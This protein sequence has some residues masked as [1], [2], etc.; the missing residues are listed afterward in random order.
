MLGGNLTYPTPLVRREEISEDIFHE[1][2]V[3]SINLKEARTLRR[4]LGYK[5]KDVCDAAIKRFIN[6]KRKIEEK[7]SQDQKEDEGE[8]EME[9][10]SNE[11]SMTQRDK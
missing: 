8:T 3:T 10:E 9:T 7:T 4:E 11:I 5:D 6:R 1:L 2:T